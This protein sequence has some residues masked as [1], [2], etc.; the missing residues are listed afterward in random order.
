MALFGSKESAEIAALQQQLAASHATIAELRGWVSQLRG[1][2][3]AALEAELRWLGSAVDQSRREHA[4]LGASKQ[5]LQA[6][7]NVCRSELV[8]TRDLVLLHEVGVYEYAHPLDDALA[9]KDAL[10]GVKQ[11]I[12]AAVRGGRGDL[13]GRLG[14]ERVGQGRAEARP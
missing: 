1:T 9:Y 11:Q 12:K 13:S 10:N 5:Q 6:E 2:P 3:A 8:E 7:V 4:A 14:G